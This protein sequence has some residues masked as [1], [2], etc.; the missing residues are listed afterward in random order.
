MWW[1]R[2]G[3]QVRPPHELGP[4][5]PRSRDVDLVF[6][7]GVHGGPVKT[8]RGWA[9]S[10]ECWPSDWL[11]RDLVRAGYRPRVLSTS[12]TAH[13]MQL[14]RPQQALDIRERA[15]QLGEQ[16]GR[17]RV[18]AGATA[19][20]FV[21]HSLGGLLVKEMLAAAAT[22]G[23]E[24]RGAVFYGTPH[25]G[26]PLARLS[27]DVV[28]ALLPVHP[29]MALMRPGNPFLGELNDAYLA[30]GLPTL[31]LAEERWTPLYQGMGTMVVPPHSADPGMGAFRLIR[32]SNH[33]DVCK[34][35][36]TSDSRYTWLLD[37]VMAVVEDRVDA[38]YTA[39]SPDRKGVPEE[40]SE[41]ED[42][43]GQSEAEGESEGRGGP[44]P[45]VATTSGRGLAPR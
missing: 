25:H 12:Y 44:G 23:A 42:S 3:L 21:A 14:A 19:T 35:L 43:E 32:G 34:P 36:R 22:E 27:P 17:A 37:F 18:G 9:G 8:W 26:S 2:G 41:G 7:H 28:A 38:A 31:S 11:A 40:E 20:V 10:C 6:V 45:A 16:L 30:L 39:V 15:R 24:R 5:G 1:D 4:A 29:T 13:I 33:M